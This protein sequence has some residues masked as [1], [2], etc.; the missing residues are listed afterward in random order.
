MNYKTADL[1]SL[2]KDIL[3]KLLSTLKEEIIEELSEKE[4]NYL[5]CTSCEKNYL[6]THKWYFFYNK[7]NKN[8]SII[9]DY[10]ICKSC[11][12]VREKVDIFEY[13]TY[14]EMLSLLPDPDSGDYV[15]YYFEKLK[16]RKV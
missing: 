2:P 6:I 1:Y 7:L 4:L 3:V 9:G 16:Q 5:H 10:P 8:M 11:Y 12:E 13:L 15:K 14:E